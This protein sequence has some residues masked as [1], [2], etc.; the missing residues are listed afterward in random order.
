MEDKNKILWVIHFA[1]FVQ[2]KG[3]FGKMG[4]LQPAHLD[5]G[6]ECLG[7]YNCQKSCTMPLKCV[8]DIAHKL[9]Y[10]VDFF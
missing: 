10:K 2:H 1:K 9:H 4:R 7:K 3:T 8:C 6:G 5:G